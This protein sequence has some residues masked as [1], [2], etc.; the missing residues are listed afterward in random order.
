VSILVDSREDNLLLEHLSRFGLPIM[1]CKL[2][3]GDI[4]IESAD[5]RLI[6]YERKR[7][8]DL[9]SSM[10]DRRL[11]GHQLRG[12]YSLYDRVELIVEGV[13]RAGDSG[14]IEI[15]NGRSGG[16]QTLYHQRSGISYRQVDSYLYSQC[17]MGGVRSWRTGSTSETANL[18]ASRFH[19]WQKDY[20]LHKSHDVL[21]T[22]N[23]T[24]QKRGAMI[25]QQGAPNAVTLMAAQMPGID[26][27]SWDIGKHFDS[28]TAMCLATEA[29][30]RRVPWTDRKGNVKHFGPGTA[31]EIVKWLRGSGKGA[32]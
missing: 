3:F 26:A 24:A 25:L 10:T 30:W 13:W 23:P 19:W 31:K 16:W 29:E 9:I 18:I 8:P 20:E 22:N 5:G 27:K 6:G 14:E 15:P 32:I 12:M 1:V 11:S 4:A 7:L 28:P 2:D 21:F 17:E